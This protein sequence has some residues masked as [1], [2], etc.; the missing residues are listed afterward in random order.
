MEKITLAIAVIGSILIIV[1]LTIKLIKKSPKLT[2]SSSPSSYPYCC[3]QIS[4][5]S[6]TW[7]DCREC[8]ESMSKLC[9][10]LPTSSCGDYAPWCKVNNGMCSGTGV[11]YAKSVPCSSDFTKGSVCV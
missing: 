5:P 8:N 9:S 3:Q 7:R 6:N 11:P 10:Q 4:D 1:I 2:S